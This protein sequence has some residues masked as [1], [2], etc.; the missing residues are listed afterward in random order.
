VDVAGRSDWQSPLYAALAPLALLRPGS[1]R[2]A[3]ALWAYAIY[4]FLTWWLLTHRLD[5]FWLPI[6]PPLAILAGLGADWSHRRGWIIVLGTILALSLLT[7]LTY[8]STALAG[9]N[10][11]TG[12]LYVLRRDIPRRWNPPMAALDREL[13]GDARPL[14]VGQAA[15]FHLDHPV[16]YNTVFN[17]E[18]IEVLAAGKSPDQLKSALHAHHITHVYVDWHEIERHR[19]PGGYGFTDYVT[20]ERFAQWVAS[21]VLEEPEA[22]GP[23]QDLYKVR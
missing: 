9:L 2:F 15:V 5:R 19:K 23:D 14:L 11:W 7:N 6:L 17:P 8:I 22:I 4:L 10:E 1:R 12:D 20:K 21:G 18:A 16:A 13:P 3:L